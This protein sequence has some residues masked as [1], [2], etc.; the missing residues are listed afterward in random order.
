MWDASP[1]ARHVRATAFSSELGVCKP[2]RLPYRTA[3]DALGAS[4]EGTFFVG[5]GGSSELSGARALGLTAI[6]VL[7]M[8]GGELGDPGWDGPVLASLNE[9]SASLHPPC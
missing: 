1:L 7:P 3:L 2:D 9:L 8:D 5:D 4:A 6:G